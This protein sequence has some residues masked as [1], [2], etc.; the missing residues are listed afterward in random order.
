MQRPC[1][2]NWTNHLNAP[3]EPV[4][5]LKHMR[6]ALSFQVDRSK[7]G[8][9]GNVMAG[10]QEDGRLG[11]K[12]VQ[13]TGHTVQKKPSNTSQGAGR[14]Q[15]GNIMMLPAST[16]ASG[17]LS[18][19]GSGHLNPER[20]QKPAQETVSAA[21]AQVGS[22]HPPPGA[23][24]SLNKGLQGRLVC[25]KEN[26]DPRASTSL[27]PIRTFQSDANSLRKTGVLAHRQSSAVTSRPVLGPKGRISNQQP[28]EEP[29]V[30]KFRKTLSESKNIS[31]NTSIRTQPLQPSGFLPASADLLLKNSG[32]NQ[33]KTSMLRQ[34]GS[35]PGGSLKH[36]GQPPPARRSPTKPPT[37]GKPQG[38]TNLETSLNPGVTLPWPRPMVKEDMDRKD[39]RLVLPGHTAACQGTGHPNQSCSWLHS[40]KTHILEDGLRGE[41]LKPELLKA[42]GMQ[43]RRIPRIPSAADRKKQL[44][45]WLASKG[46]KYKRPPM[47]QLQKQAVKPS[48]RKVKAKENQENAEQHCQVMIDGILTECLKLIEEGVHAEE[49]SAVLS[50][51]PQAEKFAKFWICQAKMLAQSGPFD[52]LQLYREAVVAGAEPIEELRETVLNILKDADQKLE[53]NLGVKGLT[54]AWACGGSLVLPARKQGALLSVPAPHILRS[55]VKAWNPDLKNETLLLCLG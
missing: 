24:H 17:R 34:P 45:E 40:S 12:S 44:E 2:R 48:C 7:K 20:N 18:P 31:Q 15:P 4:S 29:V 13:H 22:D 42:S 35:T 10:A 54:G 5:K 36:H 1:L 27:E 19:S 23:P 50:L 33:G 55:A 21:A 46:K 53:G 30:D 11:A 25:H 3:L 49:I 51:V 6:A 28:K 32:T 8:V 9:F 52:V 43:A 37:L 16:Q 41:Q 47:A 26:F 14:V 39:M 38:T